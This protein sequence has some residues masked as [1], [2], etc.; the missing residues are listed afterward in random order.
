MEEVL[1]F[2]RVL[3]H[4]RVSKL[5]NHDF[6]G[7]WRENKELLWRSLYALSVG[8]P[9]I[10]DD[11]LAEAFTRALARSD[12]IVD[13]VAWIYRTASRVVVAEMKR[14]RN[15]QPEWRD[16]AKEPETQGLGELVWA[17]WKLPANQRSAIVL[18]YEMGLSIEEVA[19]FMGIRTPTVR[20]HLFRARQR[21]RVLLGEENP[22]LKGA[23][24]G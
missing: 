9:D 8:H 10:V 12:A 17:L 14:M 2:E 16:D 24:D 19:H 7:L 18:H 5:R 20:V 11:A 21:L 1:P 13:P 15:Q 3:E 22:S 4:G 6:D 23:P